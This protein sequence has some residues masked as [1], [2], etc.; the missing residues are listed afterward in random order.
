MAETTSCFLLST[1]LCAANCSLVSFSCS[2]PSSRWCHGLPALWLAARYLTVEFSVEVF[3][4]R[5]P[6][7]RL[8]LSLRDTL[9]GSGS[10][11]SWWWRL[12]RCSSSSPASLLRVSFKF[13]LEVNNC[14]GGRVSEWV[15][16][17]SLS[18]GLHDDIAINACSQFDGEKF[19][20]L[21][22]EEKWYADF[23]KGV[24]VEIQV[25]FGGRFI[26]VE[27]T[28]EL[29]VANQQICKSNLG[30]A[31]KFYKNATMRIGKYPNIF[32]LLV[33]WSVR[34]SV[35]SQLPLS[36]L[37]QSLFQPTFLLI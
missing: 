25:P 24:G 33:I 1:L 13:L 9:T 22:G 18:S 27:G 29:A 7:Q 26:Y 17:L 12:Q 15:N 5:P 8:T 19:F 34:T 21:D 32:C 2:S 20:G 30:N 35:Y 28:Y 37:F 11:D 3:S 6:Q 31:L 23:E 16:V 36:L 4:S 10:S 14:W